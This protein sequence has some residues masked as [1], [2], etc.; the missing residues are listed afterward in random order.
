MTSARGTSSVTA[1]GTGSRTSQRPGITAAAIAETVVQN[2][3]ALQA[4][5]PAYA[6]RNDWYM[7][8]AYAVR[9]RMLDR[10]I[11]LLEALAGPQSPAKVVGYVPD[12]EHLPTPA[13]G[14]VAP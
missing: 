13:T 8:L 12:R 7:A 6:T 9:Q 10:Y 5:L 1:A 2:L 11:A 4:R 14:I 3:H